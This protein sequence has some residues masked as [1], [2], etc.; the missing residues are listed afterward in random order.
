MRKGVGVGVG[1]GVGGGSNYALVAIKLVNKNWKYCPLKEK[2]FMNFTMWV[3]AWGLTNDHDILKK[4]KKI[5]KYI[6]LSNL[7]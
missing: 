6:T 1:G 7:M 2:I 4:G 5:A 3:F